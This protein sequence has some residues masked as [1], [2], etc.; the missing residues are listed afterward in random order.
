MYDKPEILLHEALDAGLA[1]VR[2]EDVLPAYLPDPPKG[3]LLIIG[4]GKAAAAM[5]SACEHYYAEHH[6]DT[7]LSGLVITRYGHALPTQHIK[8]IEAGHPVPDK[9]GHAGTR[10]LLEL[11]DDLQKDD[12]VLCLISGGGS[13]LLSYPRELSLVEHI[14]VSEQLLACGADIH[15]MN[16]V[17]K[18]LSLIKGGQLAQR[19]QPARVISLLI[20]DVPGDD[21]SSIASGPTV[22]DES[23]FA[24]A[25]DIY[26]RY[27]L[28]NQAAKAVLQR[29]AQ[30]Q[31]SETPNA[32][33]PCFANTETHIIATA[34]KMLEAVAQVFAKTGIAPLIL[35]DSLTG[36]AK[37]AAKFHA[38]LAHQVHRHQQPITSPCA[39][40]SGGETSVTIG[41]NASSRG[42]GGRNCEF[43]LSL[44]IELAGMPNT[45]ALAAD[46]DGIDGSEDAAGAL[47]T[48]DSLPFG[49]KQ[50]RSYLERHDSYSYFERLGTLIK[51]G[52]THTNVND[53]RIMLLL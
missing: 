3:K 46:S 12:L 38:A 30:K 1:A 45:Y 48:P 6:P 22:P 47:L 34:Q 14:N 53:L 10:N 39:L 26:Q 19:A 5:A 41:S 37:E 24:D 40:I 28:N 18:H 43:L 4:V 36:E 2:P 25:L 17:R 52:P 29:G 33:D 9:A 21:P 42:R 23:T 20:S 35:T 51:T 31:L 32:S 8:V 15:E 16:I 50:A 13:A 27:N 49:I 44:A 11:L 7:S